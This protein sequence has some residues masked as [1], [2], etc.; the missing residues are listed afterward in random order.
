MDDAE[1][2]ELVVNFEKYPCLYVPNCKE[3]IL[4]CVLYPIIPCFNT[5]TLKLDCIKNIHRKFMKIMIFDAD[6]TG[7]KEFYTESIKFDLNNSHASSS[8]N[9][10]SK[11]DIDHVSHLFGRLDREIEMSVVDSSDHD[12]DDN[13][14]RILP[15][16]KNDIIKLFG[17]KFTGIKYF[18]LVDLTDDM[19]T[20]WLGMKSNIHKND[21]IINIDLYENNTAE[22]IN[23]TVTF[24]KQHRFKISKL[25]TKEP[26]SG[27]YIDWQPLKS[28]YIQNS[29]QYLE[30]NFETIDLV[31]TLFGNKSSDASSTI[32]C[33]YKEKNCESETDTKLIK[34]SSDRNGN[35]QDKIAFDIKFDRL[36]FVWIGFYDTTTNFQSLKPI[37]NILKYQWQP[38][39]TKNVSINCDDIYCGERDATVFVPV[40]CGN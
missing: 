35:T 37:H 4:R 6:L 16:D 36:I 2:D 11:N 33:N 24:I 5:Q 17:S 1:H 14:K 8:S 28:E 9:E 27:L 38:K 21:T 10:D 25:W 22:N 13:Y 12:N 23:K 19:Y 29:I 15:P 31:N 34:S 3:I 40:L 26:E 20:L 39:N 7:I 32:D 18:E 30:F